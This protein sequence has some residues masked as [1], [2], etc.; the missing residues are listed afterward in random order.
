[1]SQLQEKAQAGLR[2][3][4]GPKVYARWADTPL[5]QVPRELWP[6]IAHEMGRIVQ[7]ENYRFLLLHIFNSEWAEYL[8]EM[9]ALRT[10]IGLEAYA[11]RDP[12]VQYKRKAFELYDRLLRRIRSRAI[13]RMFH[14][15]TQEGRIQTTGEAKI[16]GLTL[17]LPQMHAAPSGGGVTRKAPAGAGDGKKGKKGKKAKTKPAR[18]PALAAAGSGRS[19]KKRRKKRKK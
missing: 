12:L 9:E 13:D 2:R 16:A 1:M 6:A 18:E 7:T 10:S 19:R 11:Q 5:G 14:Y 15:R 17:N 4:L 8:T 3:A